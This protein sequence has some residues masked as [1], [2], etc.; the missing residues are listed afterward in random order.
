MDN[1]ET[2]AEALRALGQAIRNDGGNIDGREIL[3]QLCDLASLL[4][5][6]TPV[7]LEGLLNMLNIRVDPVYGYEFAD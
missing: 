2:I 5:T 6:N 3:D 4:E 1:R 7:Q